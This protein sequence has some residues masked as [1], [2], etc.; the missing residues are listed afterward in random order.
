MAERDER[1]EARPLPRPPSHGAGLAT[2][3]YAWPSPR[4]RTGSA[5]ASELAC[6]LASTKVGW[7]GMGCPERAT[8]GHSPYPQGAG[9]TRRWRG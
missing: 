9:A 1:V 8:G 5:P 7:L 2:L 6:H 3:Q 4:E